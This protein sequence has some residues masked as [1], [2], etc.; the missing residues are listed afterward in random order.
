MNVYLKPMLETGCNMIME[1]VYPI[2]KNPGILDLIFCG[3]PAKICIFKMVLLISV[4][5][6]LQSEY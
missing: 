4:L 3:N 5:S 2:W 1:I 6:L